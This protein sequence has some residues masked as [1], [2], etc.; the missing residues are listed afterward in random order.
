MQTVL[1]GLDAFEPN[2]FERLHEQGRLPYLG[3]YVEAGG[4]RRFAVANPPQ[5]EV[6]W[7]SIATGLNP[8][9][10]GMFDFVHRDPATYA[11]N[12]SLLP[13]K[14]QLG[15]TNFVAPYSARTI[16]DQAVRQ[17]YP[18]TVLWWPAMFPARL[19]SPVRTLPGLGT[20]DIRGRLGVGTHF[21]TNKDLTS[22]EDDK[23]PLA[24]LSQRSKDRFVGQLAGPVR[25]KRGGAEASTLPLE[26]ERTGDQTVRLLL[27]K[28]TM[29]L[30][31]GEWSPIVELTF[32]MGLFYSVRALTR[33]ALTQVEPEVSL[34][35]LPLQ[36]HPLHSP[37]HYATP[38]GFV[39]QV[40]RECGPFLTIGWPQ[41]T[42][43]LEEN[44]IDDRQFLDLCHSIVAARE[45]VLMHQ[46]DHFQEGVLACVFDTLDRLQHMYWSSRPDIVEEWYE[47]L[48]ALI[49]RV[50]V[51]L[52]Q[53]GLADDTRLIVVSDHGFT[54]FDHKVHLNHWLVEQG[55]LA[56][57]DGSEGNDLR[58]I[59]WSKSSAYAIGLN[60]IYLN[61]AGREG[62]G[63]LQAAEKES[64]LN[65]L[66]QELEQWRAP[67]GRQVV[68]RAYRNDEAF[69]GPL[70][71]YG[72]DIVVGFAPGFRASQLTGL[73]AWSNAS[74]ETNHDHWAADHCIDPEAVPGVIFSNAELNNFPNPSYRDMPAIAIGAAPDS[75]GSAPPPTPLSDE[76]EKIIEE[77][78]KSLGYL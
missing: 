63:S 27:A 39:R 34:Y 37:W 55:Y 58:E 54:H 70:T 17:G 38:R 77:R 59:D 67:D 31:L 40:W 60:S 15:G 3:K 4:Y 44:R 28:Q 19:S 42:T 43:A 68:Q 49:G 62:E 76:D 75:G 56:P 16:F 20:P 71:E 9:S 64:V 73:G 46:I 8:G 61:L 22:E 41:D 11:L 30:R 12:V 57:R 5:S 10:H 29:E 1:I 47:K 48:D 78:L 69:E 65:R 52:A 14:R 50:E 32:K 18:A 7:T 6:S 23:I 26:V 25:K 35:V 45:R 72:P 51:R 33:L 2:L 36:L 66:C 53:R 24:Y 21:T 13:T 74:L